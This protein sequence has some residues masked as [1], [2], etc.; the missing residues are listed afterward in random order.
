MASIHPSASA[1]SHR[2]RV[3][4]LQHQP[5]NDVRWLVVTMDPEGAHHAV[6]STNHRPRSPPHHPLS[7]LK[8][9]AFKPWKLLSSLAT[10]WGFNPAASRVARLAPR[11]SSSW[12]CQWSL[13]RLQGFDHDILS[14]LSEGFLGWW[15][16]YPSENMTS[17]I[18]IM[19]F[20][21]HGKIQTMFQTTNQVDIWCLMIWWK[22]MRIFE[23]L[24][25]V[26]ATLEV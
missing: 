23:W 5:A 7:F 20:L 10:F 21:I 16:T 17:S 6:K 12:S 2:K 22:F 1:R 18:G 4:N 25:I 15:Y 11:G 3:G 13:P 14:G 26:E 19:N 8:N 9:V 24:E